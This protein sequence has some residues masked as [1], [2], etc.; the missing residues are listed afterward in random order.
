MTKRILR[1][2]VKDSILENSEPGNTGITT[3]E[4]EVII[5]IVINGIKNQLLN[6][7]KAIIQNFGTFYVKQVQQRTAR[8]PKTGE[9]VL[10][11]TKKVIRFK[12]ANKLK[13]SV[14]DL[15]D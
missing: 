3:E 14:I 2:Y 12:P 1:K 9:T 13:D 11:P 7:G 5:N 15:K 6:S 4:S 10:V 8:N